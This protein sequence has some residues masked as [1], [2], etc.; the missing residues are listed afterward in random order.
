V[1]QGLPAQKLAFS[2]GVLMFPFW[3]DVPVSAW[4]QMT[5]MFVAIVCWVTG[6]LAT[7]PGRPQ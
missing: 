1:V 2:W 4:L 3:S 6:L 7:A 5:A